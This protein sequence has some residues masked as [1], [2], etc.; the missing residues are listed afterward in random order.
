MA[1]TAAPLLP[2]SMD[3]LCLRILLRLAQLKSIVPKETELLDPAVGAR[4]RFRLSG[5]Y[6]VWPPAILFRI[7]L[8][9]PLC[10]VNAFAPREYAAAASTHAPRPPM[11][12]PPAAATEPSAQGYASNSP[13]AKALQVLQVVA[14]PGGGSGLT[15][16][17]PRAA[18]S[19]AASAASPS[20]ALPPPSQQQRALRVE[21]PPPA[22][23]L[24][25]LRSSASPSELKRLGSRSGASGGANSE[26]VVG[27]SAS[28]LSPPSARVRAGRGGGDDASDGALRR[29]DNAAA[30][31]GIRVGKTVFRARLGDSANADE[32]SGTGSRGHA[33]AASST[34]LPH[35]PQLTPKR[36][37]ASGTRSP[38]AASGA[39]VVAS[40]GSGSVSLMLF[41]TAPELLELSSL[42]AL[43]SHAGGVAAGAAQAARAALSKTAAGR[44]MGSVTAPLQATLGALPPAATTVGRAA[45]AAAWAGGGT[46]GSV[47]SRVILQ[48]SD[49]CV[50]DGWYQRD[51]LTLN[52]WRPVSLA[53]VEAA[54]GVDPALRLRRSIAMTYR[55]PRSS[56]PTLVQA[57]LATKRRRRKWLATLYERGKA[58][59]ADL[60]PPGGVARG[61]GGARRARGGDTS[62]DVGAAGGTGRALDLVA[63]VSAEG[64]GEPMSLHAVGLLLEAALVAGAAAAAEEAEAAKAGGGA[65]SPGGGQRMLLASRSSLPL[66]LPP[67]ASPLG[68]PRGAAVAAASWGGTPGGP[69]SQPPPPSPGVAAAVH[70]PLSPSLMAALMVGAAPPAVVLP[71]AAPASASAVSL[72]LT[73]APAVGGDWGGQEAVDDDAAPDSRVQRAYDVAANS[74]V[75]LLRRAAAARRASLEKDLEPVASIVPP[76]QGQPPAGSS[77]GAA[78]SDPFDAYAAS[79]RALGTSLRPVPTVAAAA[80][81]R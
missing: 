49:D 71:Y 81:R 9:A 37:A 64:T 50:P 6:P 47:A 5:D 70:G 24:E 69:S 73:S 77:G 16:L 46:G 13:Q 12:L 62:A 40:G 15:G 39:A 4:V 42:P 52:D 22:G 66:L 21:Q 3:R 10:D 63:G 45:A 17:A 75:A 18:G 55:P 56:G 29:G 35:L 57:R 65:D 80:R 7:Y 74:A 30:L 78:G 19:G 8:T 38:F 67:P 25:S 2:S 28:F 26:V 58:A 76:P 41:S 23:K 44:V 36:P 68:N 1:A 61:A 31:L 20:R 32:S 60:S 51:S 33:T 34:R 54:D 11:R 48:S 14:G 53:Q 72:A 59:T 27:S 79:W 43:S